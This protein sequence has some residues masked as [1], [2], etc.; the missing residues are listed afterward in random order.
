[1][2]KDTIMEKVIAGEVDAKYYYQ[3]GGN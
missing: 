1:M 2:K 3:E